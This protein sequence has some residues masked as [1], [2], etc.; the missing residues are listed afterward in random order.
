MTCSS[1]IVQVWFAREMMARRCSHSIAQ[2]YRHIFLRRIS[3]GDQRIRKKA[4]G[5]SHKSEFLPF[6]YVLPGVCLEGEAQPQA[7]G[8]AIVNALIRV[9]LY[10]LPE[11]RVEIDLRNRQELPG[12]LV[13]FQEERT[14]V[15]K[16]ERGVRVCG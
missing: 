7:N 11:I 13:D 4:K 10:E 3:G 14:D 2:F 9:A 8:P 15:S 16:I 12:S 6:A 1:D 5:E